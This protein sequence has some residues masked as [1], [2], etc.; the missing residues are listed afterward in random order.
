MPPAENKHYPQ[1]KRPPLTPR[2]AHTLTHPPKGGNE[3]HVPAKE[4]KWKDM[5][6]GDESARRACGGG[7]EGTK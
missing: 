1:N 4:D 2:V 3:A 7:G 5:K 6:G